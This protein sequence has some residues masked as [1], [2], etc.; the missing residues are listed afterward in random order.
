VGLEAVGQVQLVLAIAVTL[1]EQV[2]QGYKVQLLDQPFGMLAVVEVLD[3][4]PVVEQE[5]QELV[6]QEVEMVEQVQL[7][8]VQV[9][10]V[11]KVVEI[12]V[13]QEVQE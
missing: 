12:Q 2:E 6:E 11:V 1:E 13:A 5:V 9:V 7:I 4:Q 10:V 8:Q 3:I